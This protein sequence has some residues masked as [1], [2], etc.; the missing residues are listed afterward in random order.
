MLTWNA[1]DCDNLIE[2]PGA[3]ATDGGCN[4]T[5]T[6]NSAEMCGGAARI[7]ISLCGFKSIYCMLYVCLIFVIR[8]I[9]SNLTLRT[10]AFIDVNDNDDRVLYDFLHSRWVSICRRRI[11]RGMHWLYEIKIYLNGCRHIDLG[12]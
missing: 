11:W 12:M 10:I 8:D 9:S 6:G 3:P 2:S 5:C 7:K 4:M 1:L